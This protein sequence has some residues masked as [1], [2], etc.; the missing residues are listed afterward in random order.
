[1][2]DSAIKSAFIACGLLW[3]FSGV[4]IKYLN[5]HGV[6]DPFLIA[7]FRSAIGALFIFPFVRNFF[8]KNNLC[9]LFGFKSHTELNARGV[10]GWV[11]RGVFFS[12]ALAYVTN[13]LLL[14]WVFQHTNATNGVFLHF[15]GLLLISLLSWPFLR[16]RPTRIDFV[17]L[18]LFFLGLAV[19]V[20]D[21][22]SMHER[23]ATVGGVGCGITFA[24]MQLTLAKLCQWDAELKP[25]V[26]LGLENQMV[27]DCAIALL[28]MLSVCGR[29][30]A[31]PASYHS[32]LALTIIGV[33]AW[34]VPNVIF[35]IL[36]RTN[37]LVDSLL[38]GLSDP[39]FTAIWPIL[40]GFDP[41]RA[42]P[43]VGG[44]IILG[45]LVLKALSPRVIIARS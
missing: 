40:F 39:L 21:G 45:A 28:G 1:M 29:S 30:V 19:L 38:L 16:Q 35:I 25:K 10:P 20:H 24:I 7:G 4:L 11:W 23:A 43:I 5:A 14:V 15:G 41:L 22:F 32:W 12:G 9:T 27:G 44:S 2:R 3:S 17:A 31:F 42:G 26:S 6:S 13:V 8:S 18:A 33:L 36:I 37:Q 34:G